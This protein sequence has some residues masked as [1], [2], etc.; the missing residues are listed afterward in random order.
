MFWIFT[1][2]FDDQKHWSGPI[3]FHLETHE[4]HGVFELQEWDLSSRYSVRV[5]PAARG[6]GARGEPDLDPRWRVVKRKWR[7]GE[8]ERYEAGLEEWTRVNAPELRR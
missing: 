7:E 4:L 3:Q 2:P 6:G 8:L 5:Y 1:S